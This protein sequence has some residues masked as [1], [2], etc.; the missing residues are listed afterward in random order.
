MRRPL[1]LLVLAA[2]AAPLGGCCGCGIWDRCDSERTLDFSTH[3]LAAHVRNDVRK[4]GENAVALERWAE[5][6][7]TRFDERVGTTTRLYCGRPR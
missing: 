1:A 4:T 6:E 5:R 7:F 2:L 3:V